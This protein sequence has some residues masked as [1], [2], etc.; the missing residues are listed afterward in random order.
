MKWMLLYSRQSLVSAKDIAV[1]VNKIR[2]TM[3]ILLNLLII[4]FGLTKRA[5]PFLDT[6]ASGLDQLNGRC[7]MLCLIHFCCCLLNSWWRL[8]DFASGESLS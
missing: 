6:A 2:V 1:K 3:E 7:P 4:V 5:V 8:S